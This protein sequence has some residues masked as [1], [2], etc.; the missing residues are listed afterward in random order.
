ML[1]TSA[2]ADAEVVSTPTPT[3][4]VRTSALAMTRQLIRLA[5]RFA[6]AIPPFCQTQRPSGA[7]FDL[8]PVNVKQIS[9][10]SVRSNRHPPPRVADS[11]GLGLAKAPSLSAPLLPGRVAL[12]LLLLPGGSGRPDG[13]ARGGFGVARRP[14]PPLSTLQWAHL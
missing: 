3:E 7:S 1:T 9:G 6:I 12:L 2:A 14:V 11:S 10:G 13:L 4:P 8:R 5:D